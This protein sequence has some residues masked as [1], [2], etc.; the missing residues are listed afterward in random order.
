MSVAAPTPAAVAVD[1][2]TA[3][4]DHFLLV[5]LLAAAATV[6]EEASHQLGSAMAVLRFLDCSTAKF[7]CCRRCGFMRFIYHI[8]KFMKG[9]E[10]A[11]EH[12]I[13]A[14][15]QSMPHEICR[16]AIVLVLSAIVQFPRR[17]TPCVALHSEDSWSGTEIPK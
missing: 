12:R 3:L 5:P 10:F 9:G 15:L 6:V 17:H 1:V 7:G 11:I 4:S 8:R 16:L 2:A 13:I 14:Q